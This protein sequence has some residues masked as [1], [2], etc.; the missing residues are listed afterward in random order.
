MAL[1]ADSG[2]AARGK[3]GIPRGECG[4]GWVG[5]GAEIGNGKLGSGAMD[6]GLGGLSLPKG[7]GVGPIRDNRGIAVLSLQIP[8]GAGVG[9]TRDWQGL[10][11]RAFS[12]VYSIVLVEKSGDGGG[13]EER[14][15][16][17]KRRRH[18]LR[19]GQ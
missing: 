12:P 11:R 16:Y 5:S 10:A 7:V 4:W 18:V 9:S 19:A 1:H 8:M 14:S 15:M 17:S 3:S 2:C 13:V 6:D